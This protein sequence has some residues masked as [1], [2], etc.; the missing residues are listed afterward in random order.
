MA[1]KVFGPETPVKPGVH[2]NTGVQI[3]I[4]LN[5]MNKTCGACAPC[6]Q[7]FSALGMACDPK[8]KPLIWIEESLLRCPRWQPTLPRRPLLTAFFTAQHLGGLQIFPEPE[9]RL[10]ELYIYSWCLW[11]VVIVVFF[12]RVCSK[13]RMILCLITTWRF[14]VIEHWKQ[15]G[16][17]E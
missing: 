4:L 10:E 8:V 7:W 2:I 6:F 15:F 12:Y 13:M 9:R 5:Q 17:F 1:H 11:K 16:Q 14:H 3:F